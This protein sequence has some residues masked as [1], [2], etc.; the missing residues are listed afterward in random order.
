M[1]IWIISDGKPGHLN[2]SLGLANALQHLRPEHSISTLQPLSLSAALKALLLGRY[3][4]TDTLPVPDY[5]IGA[6]HSTH[7]SLLAAARV[8]GGKSLVLMKPSLPLG[9]FD[10]CLIPQH[11]NPPTRTNVIITRGALNKIRPR[12]ITFGRGM[13]LIGG[14]STHFLWDNEKV[15]QQVRQIIADTSRQW[16]LTT[17]RRTPQVLCEQLQLMACANLEVVPQEQTGPSWLAD[18]LPGK[19]QCWVTQDSVSMVYEALTGGC[20]TGI[21][22]LTPANKDKP[23]RVVVGQQRLIDDGLVGCLPAPDGIVEL[24]GNR[25]FDEASRCAQLIS[26]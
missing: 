18:H 13:I 4:S 17:S 3:P 8:T 15:A 24:P 2:Q 11:D 25:G 14:P 7:L 10:Y 19:E 9:L 22:P 12:P 6:G 16:L 21:M 23:S 26:E 5:I 20:S 1:A